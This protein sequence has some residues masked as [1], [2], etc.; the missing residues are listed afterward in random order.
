MFTRAGKWVK[1]TI[2]TIASLITLVPFYFTAIM[3]FKAPKQILSGR[4]LL[5]PL[6]PTVDNFL[7][8]F[9]AAP[10]LTYLLNTIIV[11]TGILA[12]QLLVIIP[13]A[14]VFA[15]IDFPFSGAIFG[16][17]VIQIMLPLQALIVPNYRVINTLGLVN[18]R[19]ALILPFVGSGYCAFLLRQ[20]FKQVPQSLV[21]S[22]VIDGCTH[23]GLIRHVF[24]PL[25][26]PTLAVFALI[27]VATHWN[28]YLWPLII[29]DNDSV[30]TL[31]IGLGM[32][33]QH[34]SGA[35]WGLLMAG[36]LFI[37]G[38]LVLLFLLVQRS[39][40]E[41]FMSSGIKG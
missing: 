38:P 9:G 2:L 30:R 10:F 7:R 28:D 39:F 15:R 14:Y 4:Y 26:K 20:T 16:L 33:V 24:L 22:A 6:H 21:D 12:L 1:Y 18:T 8:V 32:F 19:L 27:S 5:P 40:I 35:D 17:Y 23:F 34:Q 11:V 13:A 29:T 25:A 3:A 41:S 37:T 36:T 31:T